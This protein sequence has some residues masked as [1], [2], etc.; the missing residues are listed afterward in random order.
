MRSSK[1]IL[2]LAL[3]GLVLRAE[4]LPRYT[5]GC[6]TPDNAA[7]YVNEVSQAEAIPASFPRE[8]MELALGLY[9]PLEQE[10]IGLDDLAALN[11]HRGPGR[12]QI[13]AW[14][15]AHH[16]GR[17]RYTLVEKA[18]KFDP[19]KG[20]REKAAA[21]LLLFKRLP[22]SLFGIAIARLQE[23][24]DAE[25]RLALVHSLAVLR[26]DMTEA[27]SVALKSALQNVSAMDVAPHLMR[28]AQCA[29]VVGR[30]AN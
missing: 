13:V 17:D 19:D 26:Y 14:L 27:Q 9:P 12:V 18:L 3:L 21:S 20:V 4:A 1:F 22:E 16:G 5:P 28:E 15:V 2:F 25:V 10:E 24:L 11:P 23:D 29:L 30:D 8:L 6:L 7:W